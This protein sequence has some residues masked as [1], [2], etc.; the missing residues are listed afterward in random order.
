MRS[1]ESFFLPWLRMLQYLR[2]RGGV[3]VTKLFGKTTA[4][5]AEKPKPKLELTLLPK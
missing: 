4:G 3:S 5:V 2:F 1:P